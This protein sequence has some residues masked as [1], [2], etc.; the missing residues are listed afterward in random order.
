MCSAFTH[1]CTFTIKYFYNIYFDVALHHV[2][3][4]F[5]FVLFLFWFSLHQNRI[6]AH[7]IYER[8][9]C[10]AKDSVETKEKKE[11]REKIDINAFS[12]SVNK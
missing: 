11:E 1:G 6:T 9:T 4:L 12:M 5:L 10:V 2:S 8:C 7:S 3:L